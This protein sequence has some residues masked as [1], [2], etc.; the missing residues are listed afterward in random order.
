[1]LVPTP[2]DHELSGDQFSHF[3]N[4]A[5]ESDKDS[6]RNDAVPDI[7]LGHFRNACDG[8]HVA[9]CQAV[10]HVEQQSQLP[11]DLPRLSEFG[12]FGILT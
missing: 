12:Q 9:V 1:M 2:V 4:G 10:P 3:T 6:A 7:Q 8:N 11:S 5:F